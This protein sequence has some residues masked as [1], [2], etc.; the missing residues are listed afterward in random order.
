[1]NIVPITFPH[2]PY[3]TSEVDTPSGSYN[4]FSRYGS[5]NKLEIS[6]SKWVT[7]SSRGLTGLSWGYLKP[8]NKPAGPSCARNLF[9][10]LRKYV[11]T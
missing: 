10:G 5:I 9:D 8:K 4:I 11:S 6:F 2:A 7:Y 3:L 1:M